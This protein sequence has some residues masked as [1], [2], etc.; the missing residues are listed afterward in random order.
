M[1]REKIA[2]LYDTIIGKTTPAAE[3]L[4]SMAKYEK[5]LTAKETAENTLLATLKDKQQKLFDAYKDAWTEVDTILELE[6]FRQGIVTAEKM[7]IENQ[8]SGHSLKIESDR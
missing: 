1:K 8:N 2:E 3:L 6:A 5:E 7:L 4:L